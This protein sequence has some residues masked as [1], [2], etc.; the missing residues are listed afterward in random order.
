MKVPTR[1]HGNDAVG[2]FDTST[3]FVQSGTFPDMVSHGQPGWLE[4][5]TDGK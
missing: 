1:V 4:K 2:M 5:S 3:Q